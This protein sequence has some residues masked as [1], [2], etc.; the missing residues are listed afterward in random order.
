MTSSAQV[1]QNTYSLLNF[2]GKVKTLKESIFNSEM[3]S[4]EFQKLKT[5]QVDITQFDD[6][7]KK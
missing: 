3:T 5:I 2:K 6:N 4:G 7:G 1:V